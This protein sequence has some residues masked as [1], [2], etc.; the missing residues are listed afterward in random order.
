MSG[1]FYKNVLTDRVPWQPEIN[2]D[3]CNG[4]GKCVEVCPADVF[5]LMK[6][7]DS[8][9]KRAEVKNHNDC[10]LLCK[11]CADACPKKAITL[12]DRKKAEEIISNLL[13]Q[14]SNNPGSI[15][16]ADSYEQ[17]TILQE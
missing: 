13:K 8:A 1:R 14:Y 6:S 2:Y 17:K 3:L 12:P 7:I 9:K 10:I 11:L 15:A 4:N 16:E 5:V